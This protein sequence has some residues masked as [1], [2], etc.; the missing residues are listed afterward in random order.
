MTTRMVKNR[1]PLLL[2]TGVLLLASCTPTEQ[3]Q[4]DLNDALIGPSPDPVPNSSSSASGSCYVDTFYQPAEQILHSVDILFVADTSGS[5]APKRAKVADALYA[6][7]GALPSGT[8]YRIGVILAHGSNDPAT[9][10][11]YSN[12]ANIPKVLDSST[13]SQ[14]AIQNELKQIMLN[15]PD[16]N[17]EQGEMGSYALVKALSPSRLS[18]SRALGFFRPDAA[19]AVVTISD[20]NDICAVYPN[21]LPSELHLNPGPYNMPGMTNSE[22]RIRQR[23]CANGISTDEV[24]NA[25]KSVQGSRP[26]VVGGVIHTDVNYADAGGNDS[27]GWGYAQ[28]VADQHGVQV[29]IGSGDYTSGLSSLGALTTTKINLLAEFTPTRNNFQANSLQVN[30]DDNP[31]RF[32]YN[33]N[34]N[35]LHLFDQGQPRSKVELRYCDAPAGNSA[36]ATSTATAT[37]TSTA[38]S[39]ATD[40][41]TATDTGTSTA[42]ETNTNTNT[43]TNTDTGPVIDPNWQI[44]GFDVTAAANS[45]TVLWQTTGADTTGVIRIGLAPDQLNL[46]TI[47]VSAAGA[48]HV[49]TVSGLQASTSY[50]FQVEATDAN[51]LTHTSLVLMKVTKAP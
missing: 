35:E 1:I 42:T 20:E 43:S 23:D 34:R 24:V 6:F 21:P 22:L 17:S 3:S 37:D 30:V 38:T 33:A 12:S 36:T 32:E 50:Y 2:F 44:R 19:L 5:M 48:S 31:A 40:T 14:A 18:E 51:G 45:A 26:F 28:V 16:Y 41:A 47:P 39:T 27:F 10:S 4:K 49:V 11:L 15:A 29:D 46:R 9:G 7:V 13:Q 25:L 8:D